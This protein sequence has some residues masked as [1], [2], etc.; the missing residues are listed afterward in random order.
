MD[1]VIQL[2]VSKFPKLTSIE[3][4]IDGPTANES[5]AA[6]SGL[7][8]LKTL[9]L[10]NHSLFLISTVAVPSLEHFHCHYELATLG[11]GKIFKTTDIMIQFMERHVKIQK[12]CFT[13]RGID[14]GSALYNSLNRFIEV[15]LDNFKDFKYFSIENAGIDLSNQRLLSMIKTRANPGFIFNAKNCEILKRHDNEIV[16]KVHGRWKLLN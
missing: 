10:L 12:I 7:Q 13:L 4:K 1:R 11:R 2:I 15:A 6:L 9:K 14:I 16:G 5:L 8:N 3:L